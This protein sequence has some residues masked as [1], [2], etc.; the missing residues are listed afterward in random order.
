MIKNMYKAQIEKNLKQAIKQLGFDTQEVIVTIP[1]QVEFGEYTTNSPLVLSKQEAGKSYQNAREI[2]NKIIEVLGKPDYLEKAEVAGP[3]FINFYLKDQSLVEQLSQKEHPSK[4]VSK[5]I[6]VEYADPNTHKAFHLGHLR[7]LSIGESVSRLLEYQ[8]AEVF[9]VNYGSDIGPTVA[10]ALWG[11]MHLESEFESAKSGSLREKAEFLGKAYAYAHEQYESSQQSKEE[12]DNLN[13]EVYQ[14]SP[15]ILQLWDQTKEWSLI[16]FESIY[17]RTGTSFDLRV[18]ESEVDELGKKIVEENIGRVFVRD[19]GAVIFPGEK[20]GLHTRVFITSAGYPTYEGK[21]VGLIEKYQE[22]FP[23]DEVLIL[24]DVQQAGYFAV[25]NRAIEE[26][27]PN[28]KGKKKYLG[29]GFVTLTSGKMS[30]RKGTVV[31]A[32]ALIDQVKEAIKS[33]RNQN[34]IPELDLEKIA[35]AAIKFAYLKYSLVSEIAIDIEK[36]VSIQGDSGPYLLYTYARINSLLGQSSTKPEAVDD[37]Q[38]IQLEK[39]EREVLRQLEY[40]NSVAAE[41]ASTYQPNYLATYLLDLAKV[42]NLFYQNVKVMGSDKEQF[43]L[44]LAKK[45]GETLNLGLYLLGIETVER[46]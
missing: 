8:G 44:V 24:S 14:R 11:V 34:F 25:V 12:I 13:K 31:T 18:N 15:G 37:K 32:D 22:V 39:S 23:F 26:I 40:F 17:A 5:K 21:E 36:S 9:R 42:F 1:E 38:N 10:K 35:I 29:F 7:T 45:V 2:A 6:L 46:M 3:G 41:A 28:L 33:S 30:S 16:Y 43:R 27:N 20:Y 19:Q 4:G